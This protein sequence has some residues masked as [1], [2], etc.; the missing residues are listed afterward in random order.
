MKVV[1][2][3][4]N[5]SKFIRYKELLKDIPDIELVSLTELGITKKIEEPYKSAAENA[6]HKAIEYAKI[7]NLPT[8][9]IDE[10]V[11]TNFLPQNEQPGVYVRRYA[12][13]EHEM[14][15]EEVLA[16]WEKIFKEN[17]VTNKQFIWD[18][19]IAFYNPNNNQLFTDKIEMTSTVAPYF[20]DKREPGYPMSSFLIV[21]GTDKPRV[22]LSEHEKV[23][24]DK[25]HYKNFINNFKSWI[26]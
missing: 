21:E 3:T 18:F 20:S 22:E 24:V 19:Q 1:I 13:K 12:N 16:L 7:T 14:T 26:H 25:I 17:T 6:L 15:D 10:A 5:Q 8:L 2:A 4:H 23:A 11:S 9:A